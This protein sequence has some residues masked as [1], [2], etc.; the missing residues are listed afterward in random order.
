V[1]AIDV[2]FLAA[3]LAPL[4]GAQAAR[5]LLD[6][7]EAAALL[8]VPA[9]WVRSEARAGRIPSIPLGRYVRFR[10]SDLEAWIEG[11]LR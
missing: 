9:S 4:L 1:S 8:N 7:G 6:A 11:R 3:E 2:Q 10:S 5:P